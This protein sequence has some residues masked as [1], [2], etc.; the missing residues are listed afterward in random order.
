[1]ANAEALWCASSRQQHLIPSAPLRDCAD[2]IKPGEYVRDLGIYINS[3]MSM[4]T[5]MSRT[6]SS[7]FASLR[8]IRSIRRTVSKPVLLSLVTTMVL[9]RLDYGSVTLN[10]IT[11]RLMDRLQS[12]LNAAVK[13]V[14]SSRKYDRTSARHALA[15]RS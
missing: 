13:L 6:V 15:T 5:R 8:H 1:M 3:D 9:S 7:C 11:K 4:K 2:D 14:F 12:V 10:D